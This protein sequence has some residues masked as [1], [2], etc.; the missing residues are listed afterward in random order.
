MSTKKGRQ[1][2][3]FIQKDENMKTSVLFSTLQ[4]LKKDIGFEPTQAE[5]CRVTG[6]D[7]RA[8]SARVRRDGNFPEDE[9]VMIERAWMIEI[10][11]LSDEIM[12]DYYPDVYGSCGQ[13][14]FVYS[15]EKEV[16][17]VPR[18]SFMASVYAF[19]DSKQYSIINAKGDSMEPFLYDHDKLIVEQYNGEHIKDNRIYVFCYKGE[20]FIKRLVKNIDELIVKSDNPDPAYRPRIIEKEDMNEVLIIGEIVG[21]M[22]NIRN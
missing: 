2:N 16:I 20:L 15:E 14:T 10:P 22:R 21:L 19:S 9:I 1:C 6:V 13:G 7:R 8:M 18:K 5:V 11:R 17:T 4:N 3:K 12:L